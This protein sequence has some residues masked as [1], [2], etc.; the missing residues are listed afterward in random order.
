VDAALERNEGVHVR[1][2][3]AAKTLAA[4]HREGEA[5]KVLLA[6]D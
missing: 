2:I 6:T 3:V 1:P 5:L 4:S